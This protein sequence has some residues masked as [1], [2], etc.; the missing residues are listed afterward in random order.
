MI[1]ARVQDEA[2]RKKS[3]SEE[4]AGIW[5]HTRD[6]SV[7]GRL[8]DDKD[9]R[10]AIQDAKGLSDRFGAGKESSFL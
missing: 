9:R 2:K 8:M 10:R 5:D 3:P 6:M 4:P 7:G 1:E